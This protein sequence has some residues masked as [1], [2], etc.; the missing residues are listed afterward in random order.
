MTPSLQA[1]L[2]TGLVT[3]CR[4]WRVTRVDGVVLRFTD[5]DT[6]VTANAQLFSAGAG[7]QC[8]A[9][10]LAE[11]LEPTNLDITGIFDD[12][13]I[14]VAHYLAGKYGSAKVELGIADWQDT[15]EP[16]MWL[17]VGT[18]GQFKRD[19]LSFHAQLAG[20][21]YRLDRGS[22]EA[23]TPCCRAQ[24]GDARCK[25]NLATFTLAATVAAVTSRRI[26]TVSVSPAN[27]WLQYGKCSFTTGA[28]AGRAMEIK[29]QTATGIE[30]YLPMGADIAV[31]DAVTLVAGC[32]LQ[33][34]TCS[35]KFGNVVNFRGEPFL[36]G[37]DRMT[38][39]QKNYT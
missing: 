28:N 34:A 5:H 37:A 39:N 2:A 3:L 35:A 14:S 30:L 24:L 27:G 9:V 4:V 1:K 11:G 7:L 10:E 6:S 22:A 18:M 38:E 26:F 33:L 16:I 12:A 8:S 15:T 23:T 31:G 21:A 20:I 29:Q 17:L 13:G 19:R 32:D 36:P 25:A